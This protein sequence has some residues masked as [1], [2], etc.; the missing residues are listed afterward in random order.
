MDNAGIVELAVAGSPMFDETKLQSTTLLD[1]A[2]DSNAVLYSNPARSNLP[3]RLIGKIGTTQAIAGVWSS[4][5]SD[6]VV[7]HPLEP[8]KEFYNQSSILAA[9]T[10]SV[11]WMLMVSNS[12]SLP[13]GVWELYGYTKFQGTG[14]QLYNSVKMRWTSANGANS[15]TPPTDISGASTLTVETTPDVT[16]MEYGYASANTF[17]QH[18]LMSTPLRVRVHSSST[19]YLVPYVELS[20]VSAGRVKTYIYAKRVY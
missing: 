2:A 7:G 3:I 19:V 8:S 4:N 18:S 14:I 13:S 16:D 11:I 1:T 20:N 6:I 17:T 15:S 5:A 9:P 10:S 12:I